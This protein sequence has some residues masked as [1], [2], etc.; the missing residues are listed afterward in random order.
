MKQTIKNEN[1]LN[2]E[3]KNILNSLKLLAEENNEMK[4]QIQEN[5]KTCNYYK[6][7]L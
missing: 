4:M 7:M 2:K 1:I 6:N 5:I 3:R